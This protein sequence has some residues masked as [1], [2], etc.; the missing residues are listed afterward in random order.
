[1]LIKCEIK[2][3]LGYNNI[4]IYPEASYEATKANT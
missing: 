1:M 2:H 4:S 3:V